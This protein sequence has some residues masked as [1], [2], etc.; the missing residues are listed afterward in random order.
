MGA[1]FAAADANATT[2][3]P[4]DANDANVEPLRSR[5]SV[6]VPQRYLSLVLGHRLS[7]RQLWDRLGAAI[8][9]NGHQEDCVRLLDW[10]R[11]ACT[12][13]PAIGDDADP[14]GPVN[15]LGVDNEVILRPEMDIPLLRHTSRILSLDF[16]ALTNA[17]A[18]GAPPPAGD[19]TAPAILHLVEALRLERAAEAAAAAADR[20]SARAVAAAPKAPSTAFPV[21]IHRILHTC[22]AVTE[23][24]LPALW[25]QWAAA[26][27]ADRRRLLEH[28]LEAHASSGFAASVQAPIAT[29]ELFETILYL[30]LGSNDSDNLARG[31]QPF[32]MVLPS[33]SSAATAL[34]QVECFDLMQGQLAAPSFAEQDSLRFLYTPVI[35]LPNQLHA[36]LGALSIV[37]DVVL[38]VNHRLS[39][40]YRLFFQGAW[41]HCFAHHLAHL[42]ATRHPALFHCLPRIARFIQ[43]QLIA[44]F[45]RTQPAMPQPELPAF[46]SITSTVESKLFHLFPFMPA[47]RGAPAAAPAAPALTPRPVAGPAAAAA[48]PGPRPAYTPA[49]AATPLGVAPV[50][51]AIPPRAPAARNP[52]VNSEWQRRLAQGGRLLREFKSHIPS[53][54]ATDGT[55]TELCLSYHIRGLCYENCRRAA[56]HRPLTAADTIKAQ[57]F[58]TQHLPPLA[59]PATTPAAS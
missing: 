5:L 14:R 24:E 45:N 41:H 7:P 4:F 36:I 27:R 25:H 57:A 43:L 13:R 32:L 44:Y 23:D 46:A 40:H 20:A 35:Q 22:D 59:T 16:P 55:V 15:S 30:Q 1:A 49:A 39:A 12:L 51:A 10:I 31:L 54:T 42:D 11:L 47:L 52:A 2:I 18:A 8:V 34:A 28:L 3:G 6:W 33:G 38:G 19:P 9:G 21:L 29:K 58:V 37:L 50:Q 17:T 53:A 56:T 26:N 48:A